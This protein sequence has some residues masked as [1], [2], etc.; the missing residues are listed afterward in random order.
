MGEVKDEI[1]NAI[2]KLRLDE[3]SIRLLDTASGKK[4]FDECIK[5]F[6]QS[7]DRRWWWENFKLPSYSVIGLDYP[8]TYIDSIIPLYDGNVWLIAED[9]QEPFY[10]VYDCDPKVIKDIIGECFSFE[11]Y[12]IDKE[13]EWLLCENHHNVLIAIGDKLTKSNYNWEAD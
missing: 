8:F 11:Y 4:I 12:I 10:P 1:Q 2:N 3:S 6:V 13:K 5:Y 9:D 7:G